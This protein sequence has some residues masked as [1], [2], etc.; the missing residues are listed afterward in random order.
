MD[1]VGG[2]SRLSSVPAQFIFL[3]T[4][5]QWFYACIIVVWEVVT[6]GHTTEGA[7]V[8]VLTLTKTILCV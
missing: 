6:V 5:W 8:S 1:D 4:F 3:V 2:N 7:T